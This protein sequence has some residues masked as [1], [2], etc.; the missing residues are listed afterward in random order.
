MHLN[1]I[2]PLL[3]LSGIV[4]AAQLT[5]VSNY[6]GTARAK[7]GMYMISTVS[8]SQYAS[9]T[10]ILKVGLRAR[11]GQERCSSRGNPQLPI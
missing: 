4:L 11:P 9:D 2:V 10:D 3:S 6:G 1:K 7:P 5:Q 8:V